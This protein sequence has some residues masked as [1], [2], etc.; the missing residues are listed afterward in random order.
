MRI[1]IA[2]LGTQGQK[3]IKYLKKNIEYV[4]F[5]PYSKSSDY[6]KLSEIKD[7]EY[8][9]V[10]LCIPDRL[11]ESYIKYF[12]RKKKH[13][14]VEKPL[15]LS[16]KK[17]ELLKKYSK[18]NNV[19]CYT[20]Y[21]HRFEPSFIKLRE[22]I[23]KNDLGEIYYCRIFYGNGTSDLIK[24]SN[25]K[26][27]IKSGVVSDI[28]SHLIDLI[29]FWF[30]R[31]LNQLKL[32]YANKFENKCYDYASI[33]GKFLKNISIDLSMS[34]CMWKNDFFLDLIGS[35]GSAHIHRLIKWGPSK[36]EIR[37]RVFPTGKPKIKSIIFD[38]P[39][40]PT[41]K[42]EHDFFLKII[43]KKIP[44]NSFEKDIWIS[45]NLQKILI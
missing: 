33:S 10:F 23:K 3:R 43:N 38:Q 21:N 6:K 16:I 11:K 39:I 15:N 36:L 20:A 28:G 5:D 9:A 31:N 1:L 4:T 35:K 41:W 2:G 19:I 8:D 25:W 40:D 27:Q 13:I 7:E 12:I 37:K 24:K 42:K 17:L 32:N 29:E 22:V 18:Q 45:K 26:N 30:G 44:F 34:Y 14:L